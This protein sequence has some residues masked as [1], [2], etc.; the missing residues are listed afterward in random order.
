MNIVEFFNSNN[1]FI[2]AILAILS[3]IL[4]AVAILI[5]VKTANL[6][7]QISLLEKRLDVFNKVQKI[8]SFV[9]K[10]PVAAQKQSYI[11]KCSLSCT[12][13]YQLG[14]KE[15]NICK[16]LNS[17]KKHAITTENLEIK[18]TLEKEWMHMADELFEFCV[19][20]M[21]N[22]SELQNNLHFLYTSGIEERVRRLLGTYEAFL[23]GHVYFTDAEFDSAIQ[24]MIQM[25]NVVH[26]SSLLEDMEKKTIKR[27]QR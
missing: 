3:F 19:I 8:C 10:F 2:S 22:N 16:K 27:K 24:E 12:F 15:Y 6:Q 25:S 20:E 9:E 14:S 23:F 5:S 26:A 11:G 17:I 1:G 4:S 13:L 18:D 7:I 21:R